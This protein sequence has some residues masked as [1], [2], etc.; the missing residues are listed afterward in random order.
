MEEQ[1]KAD[2]KRS[3]FKKKKM[4]DGI[5]IACV[6]AFPILH[7]LVFY[8]GVNFNSILLAFKTFDQGTGNYVFAGF[9]NFK[10]FLSDLTGEQ[11]MSICFKNSL[12]LYFVGLL[13]GMPLNILIAFCV[14]KKIP[15]EGF[16]RVV[17]F[18]PSIISSIVFVLIFKYFIDYGYP[19][20]MGK[21][22]VTDYPN[23][24]ADPRYAFGT[25]IFYGLWTGFGSGVILYSNAMTRIPV[26][27]IEYDRLE[28]VGAIKELFTVVIPLIFPTITT[29]LVTGVAG[30]FTGSGAVF[31]FFRE[32]APSHLYSFG[33]YLFVKVIGSNSSLADYPYAA[34]AGLFFTCVA[35]PITFMVKWALEKFGP[36]VEY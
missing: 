34:A 4:F 18:L 2:L 30:L 35:A 13:I 31:S 24:L 9:V 6:L 7:F 5:F 19:E 1:L 36:S 33:Y 11:L 27:L 25:I 16:F 15:F 29:F 17:L 20:I 23:L 28:G 32:D 22:H 26:S 3:G 12:T 8:V 14:F 21:L 10:T